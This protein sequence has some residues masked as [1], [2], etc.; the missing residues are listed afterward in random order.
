MKTWEVVISLV[1]LSDLNHMAGGF[2]PF[3]KRCGELFSRDS[4]MDSIWTGECQE[5]WGHKVIYQKL[6]EDKN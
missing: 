2:L 1:S 3:R 5:S 6:G 4:K